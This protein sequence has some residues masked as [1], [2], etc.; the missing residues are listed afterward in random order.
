VP[1]LLA[2]IR[3][4]IRAHGMLTP[5]GAALVAV[6]GGCDSMV[7]LEVLSR[8]ASG[9]GWRLTVAHFNHQLRGRAADADERFVRQA[10][11]RLH[12][13]CLVGH[14]Q[15]RLAA[16]HRGVSV[17]MAARELR[18]AFLARCARKLGVTRI[19]LAHQAD[20]Q[21]ETF[22]L[23]LQRGTGAGALAGMKWIAPSPADPELAL[24]RPLLGVTRTAL[25]SYARDRGVGFREDATNASLDSVRN[26]VRRVW[27]P[28]LER[29]V[30]AGIAA[31]IRR[32]ME[33]LGDQATVIAALARKWLAS[34]RRRCFTALEP[35]VQREVLVIELRRLGVEPTFHRVEHLRLHP[36]QRVAVG[37]GRYVQCGPDGVLRCVGPARVPRAP[38][39]GATCR[40]RLGGTAGEARFGGVNFRWRI[41]AGR[42]G[43][44]DRL[45]GTAGVEHFDADRVG[46]HFTLRHWQAG[47]RFQPIGL[48]GAA[49]LQ[50]LFTNAKVP[51]AERGRRVLAVTEGGEIFWVEGL[52]LGEACKLAG[53]S[54]RILEWRWDAGREVAAQKAP[55]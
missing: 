5:G 35:A 8:L 30:Q 29:H 44:A 38:G 33:V 2:T 20:D 6:S 48:P 23:R 19:F 50:D 3:E 24:L 25:R 42:P 18:H 40:Y 36:D 31:T 10:A 7:L 54:R 53:S 28:W 9:S 26:R 17:E 22:L 11:Q 49:K 55:C 47:D 16:R 14:E 52:R 27:L 32:T 13:R 21:V 43:A 46:R 4:A 39:G 51:R 34:S 45:R 37:T 15:V 41:R 12:L 1:D